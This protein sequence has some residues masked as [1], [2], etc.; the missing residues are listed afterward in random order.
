M[1]QASIDAPRRCDRCGAALPQSDRYCRD[2]G[3]VWRSRR[4]G[5]DIPSLV[6]ILATVEDWR[7]EG[8]IDR[9][10]F[11]RL[12]SRY[13]TRLAQL[14]PAPAA[15]A[16]SAT[17]DPAAGGDRSGRGGSPPAPPFDLGAWAARRQADVLLYLGAFLLV[18]AAV[19]FVT[20]QGEA[21][22]PLLRVTL[23]FAYTAAFIVVGIVVPRW[24]RVR[25]A[26]PVFLALG[27]LLTPLDILVLYVEVFSD[28][29][30]PWEWVWLAGSA[31]SAVFY[32]LLFARD[33]G[34]LY[35]IPAAIALGSAWAALAATAELPLE[36]LGAWWMAAATMLVALAAAAGRLRG[37]VLALAISIA[38]PALLFAHFAAGS[39]EHHA[40][41]PVAYALLTASVVVIGWRRRAPWMLLLSTT[42]ATLMVVSALWASDVGSL[43]FVYPVL[44]AGALLVAT[45]PLWTRWSSDVARASWGYAGLCGLAP[46][47]SLTLVDSV[48]DPLTAL[49]SLDPFA[50][51]W[52]GVASGLL[53][54]ALLAA[55]AWRN[56]S[57]GLGVSLDD[58]SRSTPAPERVIFGWG[59][60]AL[61]LVAVAHAQGAIGVERPDTGWA[62]AAIG[63]AV[64]A[65]LAVTARRDASAVAALLPPLI[66]V[67]VVSLQPWDRS[68]GHDA[69]L[70]ALPA[71]TLA[72][73][74][75]V[76]RRWTVA[77]ASA[78]FA[79][80]AMAAAWDAL[81]WQ[82]WTLAVAYAATGVALFAM[83]TTRRRYELA[84]DGDAERLSTLALSWGFLVAS[85]LTAAILAGERSMGDA[86]EAVATVEYRTLVVTLGLLAPLVAFESRRLRRWAPS[87]LALALLAVATGAAWP[88]LEWPV[89]TLVAAYAVAGTALFAA[90]TRWRRY[91]SDDESVA[92]I[93]LSWGMPAVALVVAYAS[94]G[95][96]AG[97]TEIVRTVEY[98]ALLGSVLVFAPLIAFEGRRLRAPALYIPATAVAMV[99]VV[100]SIAIAGPENVQAYTVP[101][102]LYLG[103]VGLIVRRSPVVIAPHMMLH[104]LVLMAGAAVLVL[105]QVE[106][107]LSPGG[108]QWAVVLLAE[109]AIFLAVAFVL[110]ARWLVVSGVI[111]MSGV[112]VR[113]LMVSGDVIPYWLTLGLAGLLLLTGGV[114]LLL[115][116]ERWERVRS[117]A[118]AW[119]DAAALG[120]ERERLEVPAIAL[121][122]A[123]GPPVAVLL[124]TG[125]GAG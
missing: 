125:A 67:S 47:A 6:A 1:T 87:M 90:L 110:S 85:P 39:G 79:G 108:T 95:A 101:V 38:V 45:R 74:S 112:A 91:A 4:L 106:Q 62:F 43:W 54:A 115:Q 69:V 121:L 12:R 34:R 100:M 27:A 109:G 98:R 75:V 46:L 24:T 120:G 29:G 33:Y 53:G 111:T 56:T 19:I 80:A 116:R 55:I 88:A 16:A 15:G 10:S 123:A 77:A 41:L 94:I 105:P 84:V 61:L 13:E 20:S 26:G 81:D 31:Y 49:F 68:S 82:L 86:I 17:R 72:L 42:T 104:E 76:A 65:V 11:E 63:V 113:S 32:G 7:R 59:A 21:L 2:C 37:G 14:R 71:V 22:G 8:L 51:S 28:R 78:V 103:A 60:F 5:D 25:E 40:Q 124:A 118:T 83:L 3:A 58:P 44:A 89:W 93:S 36:W 114:L 57:G 23:L 102:S 117:R 52:H 66:L 48:A 18:V 122:S 64:A 99:A 9:F 119:W 73:A 35:A 50:A 70:L 97:R 107:G 30:M 96:L 92:V